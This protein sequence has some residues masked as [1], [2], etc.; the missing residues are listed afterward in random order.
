MNKNMNKVFSHRHLMWLG[1]MVGLL[2][3]SAFNAFGQTADTEGFVQEA[4]ESSLDCSDSEGCA[5]AFEKHRAPKDLTAVCVDVLGQCADTSGCSIN[6]VAKELTSVLGGVKSGADEVVAVAVFIAELSEETGLSSEQLIAQ[7]SFDPTQISL[8]SISKATKEVAGVVSSADVVRNIQQDVKTSTDFIAKAQASGQDVNQLAQQFQSLVATKIEQGGGSISADV[9]KQAMLEMGQ[10]VGYTP[11]AKE[12][13][14]ATESAA[15]SFASIF[16][17]QVSTF[18]QKQLIGSGGTL[19]QGLSGFPGF[20][21]NQEEL[22]RQFMTGG[23][24]QQDLAES[25]QREYEENTQFMQ[26]SVNLPSD[27]KESVARQHI[28]EMFSQRSGTAPNSGELNRMVEAMTQMTSGMT[29][30]GT[31]GGDGADSTFG[32][33]ENVTGFTVPQNT[34]SQSD[35]ESAMTHP[36]ESGGYPMNFSK[37]DTGVWGEDLFGGFDSVNMPY[38]MSIYDDGGYQSSGMTGTQ[39]PS[40]V[41]TGTGP[42]PGGATIMPY[43]GGTMPEGM[44]PG[45]VPTGYDAGHMYVPDFGATGGVYYG[46]PTGGSYGGYAPPAGDWS[47]MV[48]GYV[49]PPTGGT[50]Q[51]SEGSMPPPPPPASLFEI[52]KW[53]QSMGY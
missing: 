10:L 25:Y 43:S 20:T 31:G 6:D 1:A 19:P 27:Q 17:D 39:L 40:G 30:G 16:G 2:S 38:P 51:H 33:A 11:T 42:I 28:Q 9:I 15:Y 22:A 7:S 45:V 3:F 5:E 12:L 37:Y 36:Y 52:F 29:Y 23:I 47:S 8:E 21:S 35:F 50:Y 44:M 24:N 48:P 4:L 53:Y 32:G 46:T 18:A 13:N 26:E 41:W 34:R 49:P 14:S